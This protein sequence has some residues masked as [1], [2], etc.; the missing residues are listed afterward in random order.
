MSTFGKRMKRSEV[1][2]ALHSSMGEKQPH[3]LEWVGEIARERDFGDIDEQQLLYSVLATRGT[4][5]LRD[6]HSEFEKSSE[7]EVR[8]AYE[9]TRRALGLA[10]DFLSSEAHVAH[11]R[12][13]PYQHLL[14]ALVR[15]FHLYPLPSDRNRVLLRRW[16]WRGAVVGPHLKGGTTGTLRQMV[17]AV[18]DS[19]ETKAIAQMLTTVV[20]PS[21][22]SAFAPTRLVRLSVADSRI[23]L[24]ALTAL[25]PVSP[26]SGEPVAPVGCRPRAVAN[27]VQP[28]RTAGAWDPG[29]EP[30]AGGALRNGRPLGA[31]SDARR[32]EAWRDVGFGNAP[33]R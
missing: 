7:A 25:G 6:F 24:A 4:D 17:R 28:C 29:S 15:F 22:A 32:C 2:D 14:V 19:G 5:V 10:I 13:V 30:H 31:R 3:R 33:D 9:N 12:L 18:V 26:L 23:V 21:A 16:F 11:A 20:S 1:F 8:E 27:V